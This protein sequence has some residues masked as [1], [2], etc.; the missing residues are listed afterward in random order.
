MNKKEKEFLENNLYECEMSRLRT[1]AKM[2][3]KKTKESRFVANA[4]KFAA[5]EAAY[6]CRNFRLDVEGIRAKAQE[7]FEL[8]KG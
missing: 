3:D 7:T 5:E 4:A 1:A 6:I 2:K 8:E